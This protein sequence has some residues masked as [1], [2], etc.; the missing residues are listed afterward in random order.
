MFSLGSSPLHQG[1]GI[2]P[3]QMG[4]RAHLICFLLLKIMM[5]LYLLSTERKLML[6][7]FVRF[8]QLF[9][10]QR[11]IS[12]HFVHYMHIYIYLSNKDL[13]SVYNVLSIRIT[14]LNK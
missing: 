1:Q 11:A 8:L 14:V 13:L 6:I 9:V 2:A 4:Y 12:Y 5:L 7:Y 3:R 10:C